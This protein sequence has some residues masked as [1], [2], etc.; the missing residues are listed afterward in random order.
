MRLSSRNAI[1]LERVAGRILG[2]GDVLTL[3]EK[4][5]DALSEE[6]SQKLMEKTI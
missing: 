1:N 3:I 4:A 5:E 2:M 6:D